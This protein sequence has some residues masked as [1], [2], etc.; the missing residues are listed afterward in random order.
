MPGNLL[1]EMSSWSRT[2]IVPLSIVQA[3]GVQRRAPAGMSVEEL[4]VPEKKLSLPKRDRLSAVFNQA[5]RFLKLWER[6]GLKEIRAKAIREAEKWTLDHMRFSNGVGGIY[7]SMMYALMAMDA[8]GYERDHPDFIE[9][10][11]QFE[12]LIMETEDRLEFEPAVSPVWDTAIAMFA[13]GELGAAEPDSM[14]RATNRASGGPITRI[15]KKR[16]V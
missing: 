14:R 8:L 3:T 10:L 2:I 16:M 11:S 5:D 13:L 9:T 12:G 6:R 7:P 15:I 1:Y 4:Y